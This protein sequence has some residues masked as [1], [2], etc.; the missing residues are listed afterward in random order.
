MRDMIMAC[1][2]EGHHEGGE[3]Y[4]RLVAGA[5][6][7]GPNDSKIIDTLSDIFVACMRKCKR[8]TEVYEDLVARGG[9]DHPKIAQVLDSMLDEAKACFSKNK[10]EEAIDIYRGV[11]PIFE[12]KFGPNSSKTLDVLGDMFVAYMK[13]EK[14]KE[15]EEVYEDLV[16]KSRERSF[17]DCTD[18]G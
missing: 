11:L 6:K 16:A 10:Y 17:Q 3:V 15:G 4:E 5:R 13:R 12:R 18:Y 7:F 1:M 2:E 14:Y 9:R 8:G